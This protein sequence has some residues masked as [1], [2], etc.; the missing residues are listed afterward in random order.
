MET[1]DPIKQL[2]ARIEA[3]L[4][5]SPES[6]ELDRIC[7][8]LGE[9]KETVS[10]VLLQIQKDCEKSDRGI[11]LIQTG[12]AYRFGV[13]LE[14]GETAAQFLNKRRFMLSPAAMEVLSI[15][16]YNQPVTKTFISQ[17][18]GISSSEVVESLVD[19]GILQENGKLDLPGQPMS[20]ITTDKFLTIFGLT[21]LGE[22]PAL[23]QDDTP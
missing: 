14:Y 18:R 19:K 23:E 9:G 21:S 22:L 7:E 4:F 3:L 13:K 2:T 6:V 11:R 5:A 10:A 20:Y 17:I 8:F 16:A 15:A 12:T 1:T